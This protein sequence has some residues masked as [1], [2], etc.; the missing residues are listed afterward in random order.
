[1]PRQ[2]Q[3]KHKLLV[4]L[5]DSRLRRPVL[6]RGYYIM[7]KGAGSWYIGSIC[8]QCRSQKESLLF[9]NWIGSWNS[10]IGFFKNNGGGGNGGTRD[11]ISTCQNFLFHIV[12]FWHEPFFS[13]PS[14]LLEMRWRNKKL[15]IGVVKYKFEKVD[16]FKNNIAKC[17]G[18]IFDL[19][20]ELMNLVHNKVNCIIKRRYN[21]SGFTSHFFK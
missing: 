20:T 11:R 19:F 3:Q 4:L 8:M 17:D 9:R 10:T 16:W 12:F 18:Q 5:V 14:L 6:F 15:S 13:H 1:M 2:Q 21:G 7:E